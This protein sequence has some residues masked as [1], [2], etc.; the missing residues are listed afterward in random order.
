MTS[1]DAA[2]QHHSAARQIRSQM[3]S[4]LLTAADLDRLLRT[5]EESF[6]LVAGTSPP[7]PKA[8]PMVRLVE[9]GRA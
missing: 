8:P 6:D 5:M 9:G 3:R 2:R 1:L 4:Q 7:P